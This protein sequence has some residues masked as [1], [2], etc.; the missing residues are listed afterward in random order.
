MQPYSF[1]L[2]LMLLELTQ[3]LSSMGLP[4]PSPSNT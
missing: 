3:C 2:C 1:G 4:N